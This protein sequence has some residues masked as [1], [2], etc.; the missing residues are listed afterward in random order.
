[1]P[2]VSLPGGGLSRYRAQAPLALDHIK[3][4]DDNL[5]HIIEVVRDAA[6]QLSE[7]FHFLRMGNRSS[8]ASSAAL[9]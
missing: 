9:A 7:R 5:K 3:G 8:L 4:A 1:M 2:S 6:G